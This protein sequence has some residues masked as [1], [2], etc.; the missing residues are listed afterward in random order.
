MP[1]NGAGDL[2]DVKA[3]GFHAAK[4][5]EFTILTRITFLAFGV[6]TNSGMDY[7]NGTPGL[8][9]WTELLSFFGQVSVFIFGSLHF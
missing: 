5:K 6:G 9:Y 7:W 8:D 1:W 4:L 2:A 3:L